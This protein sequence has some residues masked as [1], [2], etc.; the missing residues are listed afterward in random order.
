MVGVMSVIIVVVA[1]ADDA[2]NATIRDSGG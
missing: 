2:S 1:A